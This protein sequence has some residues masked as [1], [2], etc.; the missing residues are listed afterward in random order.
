[1]WGLRGKDWCSVKAGPADNSIHDVENGM[2][3]SMDMAK[4][5][6][7][8]NQMFKGIIW[9]RSDKSAGSVKIGLEQVR[10]MM[11]DAWPVAGKPREHPGLFVVGSECPNFLRTV[12]SLPRSE[13]D[14]DRIDDKSEDH[15][16]DEVRYRIRNRG[17][18]GG[19]GWVRGMH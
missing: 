10:R 19:Q 2:G 15:V 1:M 9:G 11:K 12:P 8:G 16:I 7:I 3:I 17:R 18:Q 4:P 5:I 14:M 6:R 13:K